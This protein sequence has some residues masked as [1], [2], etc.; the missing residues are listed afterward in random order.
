MSTTK[1]ASV[2]RYLPTIAAGVPTYIPVPARDVDTNRDPEMAP[3]NPGRPTNLMS[4]TSA[5]RVVL[6]A[7]GKMAKARCPL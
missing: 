3:V 2:V 4:K 5:M 7:L 1:L 6:C